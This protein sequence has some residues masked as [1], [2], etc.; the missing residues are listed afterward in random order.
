MLARVKGRISLWPVEKVLQR[1]LVAR[2]HSNCVS[3]RPGR[4]MQRCSTKPEVKVLGL[5]D[6]SAAQLSELDKSKYSITYDL[7]SNI[8]IAAEKLRAAAYQVVLVDLSERNLDEIGVIEELRSIRPDVD[9]IVLVEDS[10]P[11][12]VIDAI[13]AHA[14]SYF[15]EP[16]DHAALRDMILTAAAVDEPPDA[17]ELM[18]GS[19][20][21]LSLQIRC[22]LFTVDR[23]VQFMKEIPIDL[24]EEERNEVAMAFREMLLNGIEH[25]GKLN[26]DEW[27]RVSRI[28][29]NRTL[30][31][32]ILD[33]GKGFS[34]DQLDHAAVGHPDDPTA[35]VASREEA[36][37]R[38]GGFG[39][40]ITSK[41]VDEVI[42]NQQGNE[43]VLIKYLAQQSVSSS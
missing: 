28:R 15:S 22:S 2:R 43:V 5:G 24:S 39:M 13:R 40:L 37:I 29:T 1:G 31:Y 27:V 20:N 17:I 23:L 7:A 34:R 25:G 36:G 12:H 21:Y 18:S 41:L 32:H 38:P 16:I 6:R 42:Y 26:P 33:P 10:T 11:Q 4:E 19:V 3:G 35:H 30:V 14:F 8:S 9:V